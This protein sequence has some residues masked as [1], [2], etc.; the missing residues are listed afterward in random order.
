MIWPF[1]TSPYL[2]PQAVVFSTVVCA[3]TAGAPIAAAAAAPPVVLRN[4]RR[5]SF[6]F[7]VMS[8]SPFEF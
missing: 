4:V 3:W 6:H 7:V 5:E 1:I 2:P 8:V